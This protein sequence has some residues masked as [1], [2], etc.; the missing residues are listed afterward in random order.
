MIEHAL[1]V[2]FS[3]IAKASHDAE[4][5]QHSRWVISKILNLLLKLSVLTTEAKTDHPLIKTGFTGVRISI[6]LRLLFARSHPA[7]ELTILQL[8]PHLYQLNNAACSEGAAILLTEGIATINSKN[9][10]LLKILP[11]CPANKFLYLLILYLTIEKMS[12]YQN[13]KKHILRESLHAVCCDTIRKILENNKEISTEFSKTYLRETRI[14]ETTKE[15]THCQT[16]N[17]FVREAIISIIGGEFLGYHLGSE[18]NIVYPNIEKGIILEKINN[19]PPYSNDESLINTRYIVQCQRSSK[20]TISQDQIVMTSN[21]VKTRDDLSLTAWGENFL[22]SEDPHNYNFIC[23]DIDLVKWVNSQLMNDDLFVLSG[24]NVIDTLK[25]RTLKAINSLLGNNQTLC[26]TVYSVDLLRHLLKY[27]FKEIKLPQNKVKLLSECLIEEFKGNT[28]SGTSQL[29]TPFKFWSL[30]IEKSVDKKFIFILRETGKFVSNPIEFP[31]IS[32]LPENRLIESMRQLNVPQGKLSLFDTLSPDISEK[33][34]LADLKIGKNS[35]TLIVSNCHEASL[36][37]KI[38]E[39]IFVIMKAS[40]TCAILLEPNM[41]AKLKEMLTGE[42]QSYWENCNKQAVKKSFICVPLWVLNNLIS[43]YE[44]HST[45]AKMP[46]AL[47]ENIGNLEEHQELNMLIED[48]TTP[49]EWKKIKEK[50]MIEHFSNISDMM[51]GRAEHREFY[52]GD[53]EQKIYQRA[54]IASQPSRKSPALHGPHSPIQRQPPPPPPLPT[55]IP[56]FPKSGLAIKENNMEEKKGAT[57]ESK[58]EKLPEDAEIDEQDME[59]Y[60]NNIFKEL[61]LRPEIQEKKADKNRK[62]ERVIELPSS[63]INKESNGIITYSDLLSDLHQLTLRHLILKILCKS[64]AVLKDLPETMLPQLFDLLQQYYIEGEILTAFYSYSNIQKK[65]EKILSKGLSL[66]HSAFICF[67]Q[68]MNDNCAKLKTLRDIDLKDF[69][70]SNKEP[71]IDLRYKKKADIRLKSFSKI[72]PKI[73]CHPPFILLTFEQLTKNNLKNILN[74][75]ECMP[76]FDTIYKLLFF[77]VMKYKNIKALCLT[78]QHILKSLKIL[79]NPLSAK[80]TLE[81]NSK[82]REETLKLT[83]DFMSSNLIK[84]IAKQRESVSHEKGK[85][86]YAKEAIAISYLINDIILEVFNLPTILKYNSTHELLPIFLKHDYIKT[87]CLSL[88]PDTS[89]L[90]KSI[91]SKSINEDASEKELKYN[92]GK[93]SIVMRDTGYCLPLYEPFSNIDEIKLEKVHRSKQ[94]ILFSIKLFTLNSIL[95]KIIISCILLIVINYDIADKM[96]RTPKSV[97]Q[98][99]SELTEQTLSFSDDSPKYLRFPTIQKGKRLFVCKIKNRGIWT[100]KS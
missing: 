73:Q 8:L 76:F 56:I 77:R 54:D 45:I 64:T 70:N 81:I 14:M 93:N 37:G 46:S 52:F 100:W 71:E 40:E 30:S 25:C 34:V 88:L 82:E 1:E 10:D 6:L 9:Q 51:T 58:A 44:A 65:C 84:T 26:R 91:Y 90:L 21:E 33:Q 95:Q 53:E 13:G 19:K 67:M 86:L 18:G 23:V 39:K 80:Q 99:S 3:E 89:L 31:A 75:K 94:I 43:L 48:F 55:P 22:P 36:N 60:S 41:F 11:E 66:H 20:E 68:F 47:T 97:K 42:L 96:W 98:F 32:I 2:I 72:I 27:A 85:I 57:E 61:A 92:C 15:D 38:I 4:Q 69:N 49:D 12:F 63:L 74:A 50:K 59:K 87:A 79:L 35:I 78:L 29:F 5:K 24:D 83:F 16:V 62:I 7:C 28:V 17:P